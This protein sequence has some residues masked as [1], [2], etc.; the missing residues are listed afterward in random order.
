MGDRLEVQGPCDYL[1]ISIHASCES[2]EAHNTDDLRIFPSAFHI[3]YQFT[4]RRGCIDCIAISRHREFVS[5][6]FLWNSKYSDIRRITFHRF[7]RIHVACLYMG[8]N[9]LGFKFQE[10]SGCF[11]GKNSPSY[12]FHIFRIE[13]VSLSV[14]DTQSLVHIY[15]KMPSCN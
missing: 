3:C 11:E 8:S 4:K 6:S 7:T 9:S 14:L 12:I 13:F 15:Q 5:H 1:S 2:G 10:V